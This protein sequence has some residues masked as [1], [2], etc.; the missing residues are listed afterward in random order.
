MRNYV[1]RVFSW[2]LLTFLRVSKSLKPLLLS[3]LQRRYPRYIIAHDKML[4][5]G[6]HRGFEWLLFIGLMIAAPGWDSFL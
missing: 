3:S 6:I 5:G 4:I 1:L 2:W